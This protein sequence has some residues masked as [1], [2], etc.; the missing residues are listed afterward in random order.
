MRR[1]RVVRDEDG[2]LLAVAEMADRPMTRMVGL[3][4]R[5]S[6]PRGEGLVLDPCRMVHT[7]FMRFPLDL[8]FI[9]AHL[10][11]TRVARGVRPFRLAWGGWPARYTLELPAGALDET[12]V[13]AGARLRFE[14]FPP[15]ESSIG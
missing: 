11:V 13:D 2:R 12:P 6:L 9:D 7:A 8:V 15:I 10:H 14:P 5:V 3:L 4:G 1:L